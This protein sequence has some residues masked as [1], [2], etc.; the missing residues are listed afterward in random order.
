MKLYGA[1]ASPYVSRVVLTARWKGIDLPIA[2]TPGGGIRS[3]EYQAINPIG[4]IPAL[5]VDGQHLAESVVI[6]EYLEDLQRGTP[7]LPQ[8]AMARARVRLLIRIA[9]L[10]VLPHAGAIFRNLNPAKRN[11]DEIAA[12]QAGIAKGIGDLEKFMGAGPWAFGTE[13]SLADAV[14]VPSFWFLFAL[15]PMVGIG[16]LFADHP[17]L[18]RWWSHVEADATASALYQEFITSF[19]AF[20]KARVG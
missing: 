20:A 18:T 7:L 9:D 10:Y 2:P 8:D 1:L 14:L 19:M 6:C 5:D 17:K 13:R 15:L 12:A 11:A 16:N 3:P 4:K